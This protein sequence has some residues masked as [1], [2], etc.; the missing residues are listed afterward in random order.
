[1][2]QATRLEAS[3]VR[4]QVFPNSPLAPAIALATAAR[5]SPQFT[6]AGGD[7]RPRWRLTD[8]VGRKRETGQPFAVAPSDDIP[9]YR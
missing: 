6:A 2:G 5:L 4:W 9:L 7:T 8:C 3:S 1:M